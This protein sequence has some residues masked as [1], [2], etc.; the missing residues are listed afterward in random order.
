MKTKTKSYLA[1]LMGVVIFAANTYWLYAGD[2]WKYMPWLVSAIII[3][4]ADI[5]WIILDYQ[6]MNS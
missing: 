4:L 2:S 1:I 3:Y 6:L 5:Y